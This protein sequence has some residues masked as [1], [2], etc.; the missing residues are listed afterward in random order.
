M[1]FAP[2]TA[3]NSRLRIK[4]KVFHTATLH[5]DRRDDF[6]GIRINHLAFGGGIVGFIN[7]SGDGIICDQIGVR[8]HRDLSDDLQAFSADDTRPTWFL[9]G[10][11]R[12][13]LRLQ[14][15]HVSTSLAVV[16]IALRDLISRLH[17]TKSCQES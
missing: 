6:F 17:L 8:R 7:H 1:V 11:H 13:E 16:I 10:S 9:F 15:A 2:L 12:T 5:F 4:D 3:W 14:G